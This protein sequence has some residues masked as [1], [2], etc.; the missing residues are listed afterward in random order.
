MLT[1]SSQGGF[2]T[3]TDHN[4]KQIRP[5]EEKIPGNLIVPIQYLK[6]AYKKADEG[7]VTRAHIDRTRGN[8]FI[9]DSY[10]ECQPKEKSI[11]QVSF[12]SRNQFFQGKK[13]EQC[14][15]IT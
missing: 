6:G 11:A 10:K 9:C 7:L 4:F 15:V 8:P 12:I 1:L 5:A 14:V 2:N 13:Y 3:Q